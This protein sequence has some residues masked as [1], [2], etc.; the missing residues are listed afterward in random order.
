[1]PP[2][3]YPAR[4]L[5]VEIYRTGGVHGV[6]IGRVMFGRPGP[7]GEEAPA[8]MELVRLATHRRTHTQSHIG[9]RRKEGT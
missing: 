5:A 8:P 3:I 4:A 6:E 9:L 1:M 2:N 7:D